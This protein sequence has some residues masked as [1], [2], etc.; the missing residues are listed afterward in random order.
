MTPPSQQLFQIALSN[1]FAALAMGTNADE[2]EKQMS[3]VVLE[4][5]KS[6]C[7][8]IRRR[9]QPWI[10]NECLQHV[11]ERKQ[12][13]LVDFNRYR[14]LSQEL[15]RRMKME[16]EAYWNRVADELEEAAGRNDYHM[17]YRTITR[18]SGKTRATDDNIRKA[19]G[20]FARSAAERLERWKEFFSE[21][22]N[23]ESPQGPPPE[24]LSI[25]TPRNAFF[26]GKP[27]T[28]E[29]RKAVRSLKNGKSPGVDN[30]TAEAMKAGGEV[31]LRRLHSLISLVWQTEVIPATWKRALVVPIHEKGDSRE[32]KNYRGTSLLSIVGKVF[33]KIIQTRLQEHREQTSREEQ[34]GFRPGRGCC[35]QIF[36]ARQLMEERIR[37]GKRTVIV[38]ID[39]KSAFDCVHWPALWKS[40]EAEHVPWKI[41][42]LLQA[43]YNGSSSSVRIKNELS[44]EFPIKTGVRQGDVISP[45]LFNI[46]VD[47]IM[48]KV[49]DGRSGV[50]YGDNQFLTDLMFADD[51]AIFAET[52]TE[53]TDI[54]SSIAEVAE[55]YGLRIN[56]DKTK[57][58]TTDGSEAKVYLEGVQLEQVQEFKYLGSLSEEKKVA[59][60]AKVNSRIGKASAAFA[61]LKWCV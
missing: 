15:R 35:D 28:D 3:D 29:I 11:D 34:A 37:C 10:T 51:S 59:A 46:V 61:S 50:Q 43:T 39:F 19:D 49:F 22:Y 47:A 33:M 16:R 31:L 42:R 23:H 45:Q 48:K 36:V 1:R 26:D 53:A 32:C 5:A 60:T 27:S 13:K 24:P 9:T 20:T 21:L 55:S 6:L 30:I 17:L 25:Q 18:L 2:E 54:I 7:P 57:I 52:D 12:A 56:G 8:V 41:V 4:C 14:Q 58:M 40:L 44:E 38:F